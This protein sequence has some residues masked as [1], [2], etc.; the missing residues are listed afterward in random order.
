L[1]SGGWIFFLF[2]ESM[3][4]RYKTL[5]I[6]YSIV[7]DTPSPTRYTCKP[8]QIILRQTLPWDNI[9]EHLQQ[10]AAEQL[11][12]F[13]QMGVDSTV[14]LTEEGLAFIQSGAYKLQD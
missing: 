8:N 1:L 6:L 11:V 10:L 2:L 12:S 5:E 14:T 9:I 4:N 7:Q 3:N 13:K